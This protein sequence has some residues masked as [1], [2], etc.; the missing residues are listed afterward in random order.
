V[1]LHVRNKEGTDEYA[2]WVRYFAAPHPKAY[3][4][5]RAQEKWSIPPMPWKEVSDEYYQVHRNDEKETYI[6]KKAEFD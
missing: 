3:V 6:N 2:W 1:S 4:V 5:D